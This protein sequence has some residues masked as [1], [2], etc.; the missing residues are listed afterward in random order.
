M[1]EAIGMA[2]SIMPIVILVFIVLVAILSV[3]FGAETRRLD[4]RV[5]PEGWVGD[6]HDR[7][8]AVPT[9]PDVKR[10]PEP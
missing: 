3:P 5:P 9:S 6:P 2:D 7:P 1:E 10:P 4:T 8:E